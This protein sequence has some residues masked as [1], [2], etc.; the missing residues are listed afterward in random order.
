MDKQSRIKVFPHPKFHGG[1]KKTLCKCKEGQST[2]ELLQV[3][4]RAGPSAA[5]EGKQGSPL[6]DPTTPFHCAD[7]LIYIP[8]L[9]WD[10][11]RARACLTFLFLLY[12]LQ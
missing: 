4:A 6:P 8:V 2:A 7:T 3:G 1:D 11:T 5:E 9:G 10:V 12:A